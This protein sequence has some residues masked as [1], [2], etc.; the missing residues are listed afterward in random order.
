MI[1]LD[2]FLARVRENAARV[3]EYEQGHDG[4]DGK[5][6]CIGLII[7]ALALA[8]FKWP[9]IHGSNWAARNAMDGL[10]YLFFPAQLFPGANLRI[11]IT[12]F[13]AA[14]AVLSALPCIQFL[15]RLS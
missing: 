14:V 10:D 9:G 12:C 2:Q 5:C 13:T 6:D 4:S 15:A 1:S 3:R 11:A 7:G 8:G